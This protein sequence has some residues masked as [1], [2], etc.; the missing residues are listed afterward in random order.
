[1]IPLAELERKCNLAD[2]L[3]RYAFGVYGGGSDWD[4]WTH[5][6]R[7]LNKYKA[8]MYSHPEW[9]EKYGGNF[10]P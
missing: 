9:K 8:L 2:R 1:M 5:Y 3:Y 7:I 4:I 6:V 10:Y